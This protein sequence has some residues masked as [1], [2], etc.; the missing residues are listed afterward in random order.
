MSITNTNSYHRLRNICKG[1]DR[2][3]LTCNKLYQVSK[4]SEFSSVNEATLV[5]IFGIGFI[6]CGLLFFTVIN[7]RREEQRKQAEVTSISHWREEQREQAEVTT[8]KHWR[9][10]QI[11]KTIKHWYE[12]QKEQAEIDMDK[13]NQL[14]E[15]ARLA[16][17][18]SI[19]AEKHFNPYQRLDCLMEL[20]AEVADDI[21]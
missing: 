11:E 20:M 12:K 2:D 16:R 21:Y 10:K 4:R 5:R 15:K 19:K 13:V 3:D 7:H 18:P 9:E 14:V 6:P 8:T 1:I 17:L